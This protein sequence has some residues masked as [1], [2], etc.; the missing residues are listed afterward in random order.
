MYKE[1]PATEGKIR[2]FLIDRAWLQD[3]GELLDTDS[4]LEKGVID[5]MAMVELISF[6]EET[7]NIRIQNEELM[8]E[9]FDS[10]ASIA[11]YIK[12]KQ[13]GS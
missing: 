2:E 12:S 6:I 1:K 4:L 11:A 9:N 5:S 8:P 10:L 13:N 3:D 7:Y